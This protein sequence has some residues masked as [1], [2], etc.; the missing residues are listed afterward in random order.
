MSYTAK[1]EGRQV[2]LFS[3]F[4][5]NPEAEFELPSNRNI[6]TAHVELKEKHI[7]DG[8]VLINGEI[9]GSVE[10]LEYFGIDCPEHPSIQYHKFDDM[11]CNFKE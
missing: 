10:H 4:K 1:E 6:K 3:E 5:A 8:N 9:V 11:E 7:A 2:R